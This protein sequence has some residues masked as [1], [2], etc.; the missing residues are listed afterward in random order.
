MQ[1]VDIAKGIVIC[2]MVIGHSAIP[3]LV[4]RWIWSFHMPFFFIISA[5]FT[6]WT[7][8]EFRS[9]AIRK[10]K[11]LLIPFLIYSAINLYALPFS[12]ECTHLQYI[13][14]ILTEGWG[15]IALWFIPIFF[16]SLLICRA[17]PHKWLLV[18]SIIFIIISSIL[19][20]LSYFLPWTLSVL[21][22]AAAIM[23]IVRYFQVPLKEY[24]LSLST[25]SLGIASTLG[26]II[27]ACISHYWLLDMASDSVNPIIPLLIGI[28]G[29]TLFAITISILI[30][31]FI[32][33]MASIFQYIGR[34]TY[35]IMA[36][37][38]CVIIT[39]NH[40]F[41]INPFLKYSLLIL[42]LWATIIIRK[43]IEGKF[44]NIEAI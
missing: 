39:I 24:I 23:M 13:H 44:L 5:L 30:S 1:W 37:S 3:P 36:L 2:L 21:P 31:Y 18:A 8:D 35:E 28:G 6:S 26:I 29:G 42:I 33:P 22:Y 40:Y 41:I 9:F 10:T 34:N 7:R 43:R 19:K 25:L 4:G 14:Q 15:G 27:S 32:P 11:L 17:M 38:Q 12:L 16:L 20:H